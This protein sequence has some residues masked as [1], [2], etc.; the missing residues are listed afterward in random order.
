M[1]HTT[2]DKSENW[3]TKMLQKLH[4][5]MISH[6]AETL[7]HYATETLDYHDCSNHCDFYPRF[8]VALPVFS[9]IY[10]SGTG[11]VTDHAF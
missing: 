9:E 5:L 6:T 4:G 1:D 8:D 11:S 10:Q 3:S 2:R 7:N